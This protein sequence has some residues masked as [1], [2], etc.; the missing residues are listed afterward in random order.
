MARDREE[1]HLFATDI[2]TMLD[3][4]FGDGSGSAAR[5]DMRVEV[6]ADDIGSAVGD[7]V[8]FDVIATAERN[9][10]L[11][12]ICDNQQGHTSEQWSFSELACLLRG[13]RNGR[14]VLVVIP[15][16]G[17]KFTDLGATGTLE[18]TPSE[19]VVDPRSG[20]MTLSVANIGNGTDA[21]GRQRPERYTCKRIKSFGVAQRRIA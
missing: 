14:K 11:L 4:A 17:A 3:D 2:L 10:N 15:L 20:I 13:H 21:T 19:I 7:A 12:L 8:T 1:T 18:L 16:A 9:G 6:S 5:W